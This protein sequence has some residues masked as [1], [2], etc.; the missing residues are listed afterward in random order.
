MGVIIPPD[1]ASINFK[2]TDEPYTLK[3][4]ERDHGKSK[5]DYQWAVLFKFKDNNFSEAQPTQSSTIIDIDE[6]YTDLLSQYLHTPLLISEENCLYLDNVRPIC[7]I[8]PKPQIELVYDLVIIGAGQRSIEIAMYAATKG[9][10]VALL[11]KRFLGGKYWNSTYYPLNYLANHARLLEKL[12]Y[13]I[14]M[15]S[16]EKGE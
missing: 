12:G 5:G 15:E 16:F 8:S 4:F 2:N 7:W 9:L 3:S 11:E 10:K 14:S 6:Q 13:P 1:K